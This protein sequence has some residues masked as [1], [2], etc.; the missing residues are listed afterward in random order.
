MN[1]KKLTSDY[2]NEIKSIY[3][4]KYDLSE[5]V[6]NGYSN[7]V[8]LKYLEHGVFFRSPLG[9]RRGYE[10]PYC[11]KKSH[12][13]IY[14]IGYND[15]YKD[16]QSKAYKAWLSMLNRCYVSHQKYPTYIDCSVCDEWLTYSNFKRWF[17]NP[18]NGY[19]EGYALDKDILVKGNKVYS[20]TTCCFVPPYINSLLSNGSHRNGRYSKGV[21]QC[22]SGRFRAYYRRKSLGMFNTPEEAFYQYKRHREAYIKEMAQ[23]AY[24]NNEISLS[25]CNALMKYSIDITD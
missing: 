1:R 6:W 24:H 20:P 15:V 25:V 16:R 4:D 19:R 21:L 7:K 13:L 11:M 23:K 2:I 8:K 22:K 18:E 17:E 9:L 5:V 12:N 3:G 10:C 14:G